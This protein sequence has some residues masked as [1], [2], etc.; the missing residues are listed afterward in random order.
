MT[1]YYLEPIKF[2]IFKC[3]L[4]CEVKYQYNKIGIKNRKIEDI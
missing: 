1:I 3:A 4:Q 2:E